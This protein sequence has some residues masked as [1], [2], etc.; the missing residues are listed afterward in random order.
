MHKPLGSG[1]LLVDLLCLFL[2]L[3]FLLDEVVVNTDS[4][5][6]CESPFRFLYRISKEFVINNDSQPGCE[7]L[8][9]KVLIGL[10][11]N[12]SYIAIRNTKVSL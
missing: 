7:S 2:L 5:P 3:Y 1:V 10:S 4:Q 11:N 6:G 8:F 12:W 9:T